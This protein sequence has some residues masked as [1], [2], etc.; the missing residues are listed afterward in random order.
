[1]LHYS[2]IKD[3][4]ADEGASQACRKPGNAGTWSQAALTLLAGSFFVNQI[5]RMT[6]FLVVRSFHLTGSLWMPS[7]ALVVQSFHKSGCQAHDPPHDLFFSRATISC[8]RIWQ[9]A[10]VSQSCS[11][12]ALGFLPGMGDTIGIGISDRYF[13]LRYQVSVSVSL[14]FS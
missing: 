9:A 6:F 14:R 3:S 1:M 8:W 7:L 13:G 2:V 12:A 11:Q 4:L 10:F 5:L